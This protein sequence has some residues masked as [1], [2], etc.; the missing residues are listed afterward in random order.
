[1]LK[2]VSLVKFSNE[3]IIVLV[4]DQIAIRMNR[5]QA[6]GFAASLFLAT[7][8]SDDEVIAALE[9]APSRCSAPPSPSS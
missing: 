1:M 5:D 4:D 9:E 6:I 2:K 3:E 8:A 7:E